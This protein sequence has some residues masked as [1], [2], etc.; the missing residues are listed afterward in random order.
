M[1][2]YLLQVLKPARYIGEEWNVSRKDFDQ[3]QIKFALCFPDLYEVGMSNLGMRIL[4]G[5]LNQLVGVCCERFFSPAHDM[6]AV[7]RAKQMEIFSLESKRTLRE[8]DLIGFSLGYELSYTNV[9]NI[10]NLGNIPLKSALRDA[11]YPLVIAGGPCVL[12]P[13]PLHEFFDIFVIGEAEEVILEIVDL[14]R[15]E[16]PSFRSGKI[17]KEE[18]LIMFS[19]IEGVYVPSLYSVTYDSE[20]H[21]QEFKPRYKEVS[22]KIKKRLIKNLNQ[23]YFPL[24]WLVPFIQIVHDRLILEIMRGCPNRCRFCQARSLYFPFRIRDPDVISA[25]ACQL[26]QNTGYEE[27]SLVGLSASDHPQIEEILKILINSFKEK[28]I[29]VSLPSIKPKEMVGN[30]ATLISQIK[31]TGLTFAPEAAREKLRQVLHKDFDLVEF[32]R[33]LEQS[34]IA[35]YQHLKLYFMIGLPFEE[36]DDLNAIIELANQA[37]ELRRKVA[38]FPAQVN[39]SINTLIPKPHTAFQWF[40]MED[41]ENIRVK[42]GFLKKQNRYKRIKLSFHHPE[43]SFL[44]GV[45]ARGDRRLSQ[46]IEGA[47]IKG[48]RFDG[49]ENYFVFTKWQEAFFEAGIDPKVYLK[50]RSKDELLPWDFIDPGIS[51]EDLFEEYNK[52]IA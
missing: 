24:D 22:P 21:L 44:E 26:Y 46:V 5:I 10:L 48:A 38:K 14:Y 41:L 6:E 4:Y 36:E 39:L 43:M 27:I 45:I 28:K 16:N 19:Q 49:W 1:D 33:V 13:E 47:F 32:F 15:K 8:F 12:N 31:K 7:L 2:D 3:A 11:S 52:T 9:L 51:K 29:A 25:L 37:S 50:Q 20:G 17:S 18:F 30:L 34:F 42:Q 23:S 35:G 40:Q